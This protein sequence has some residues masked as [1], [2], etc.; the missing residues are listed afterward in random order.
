MNAFTERIIRNSAVTLPKA[1]NLSVDVVLATQNRPELL[2]R[3]LK[4]L[5]E[6]AALCE[7]PVAVRLCVNGGFHESARI[8]GETL[9]LFPF[10]KTQVEVIGESL[11]AGAARNRLL[12]D[13]AAEWIFFIDDDA[14][15]ERDFFLRFNRALAAQP[16]TDAIG[17]P[18]LTPRGS[19]GFQH[20]S[21]AVLSSRFA[22]ARSAA[23]YS[24]TMSRRGFCSEADLI[25]CNLFVRR[26]AF[27]RL[28][29]S[30]LLVSGEENWLMQDLTAHGWS[31]FYEPELFVWHE[32]RGDFR[33]FIRQIYRYGVGRGQTGRLRPS[34]LRWFHLVPPMALL[35]AVLL[36]LAIPIFARASEILFVVGGIYCGLWLIAAWKVSQRTMAAWPVRWASGLLFPVIHIA[37]GTGFL[38][39]W[40]AKP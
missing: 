7:F 5:G 4:S 30:E 33:Q 37:Y 28:Q 39:G 22:A 1:V 14:Y 2:R 10:L 35:A 15:V 11:R 3:C 23:R 32:R 16:K 38:R 20:A 21:G 13:C 12:Q 31:L 19:N 27:A 26:S 24:P 34:T 6:A 25:S 9:K 36:P 8:A 18:N 29:F 17:G 40:A